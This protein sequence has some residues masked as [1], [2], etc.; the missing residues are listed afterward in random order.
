[1][2][3]GSHLADDL[4]QVDAGRAAVRGQSATPSAGWA[5]TA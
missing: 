5:Y 3:V 1:M 2:I 4:R